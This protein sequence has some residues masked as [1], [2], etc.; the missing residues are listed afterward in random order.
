MS[1]SQQQ[2]GQLP[3][4]RGQQQANGG[5]ED[6]AKRLF[7][8]F[9][10]QLNNKDF[11]D[12]VA[13]MCP[14]EF[15]TVGYV[16][17]LCESIFVACRD[18]PDLL[19]KCDRASLFRAAERIAK[20]GLTVGDNVAWL[21]PYSG[22]VQDQ[23]GYKGAM[24]LVRR[25]MPDAMFVT[26]P[27]FANDIC[28]ISLGS[29]P[30]VVHRPPMRGGRGAFI[31]CYALMKI[32]DYVDVEWADAETIQYVR[33]KSPSKNSPAWNNWLEEQ[34]RKIPLKRLCKRQAN[35]R[36][37]DLEDM[38]DIESRTIDGVAEV[39]NVNAPALTQSADIPMTTTADFSQQQREKDPVRTDQDSQGES[40]K[41]Q[42]RAATETV[43]DD[44]VVTEKTGHGQGTAPQDE[45]RDGG[46]GRRGGK[47]GGQ[48]GNLAFPED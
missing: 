11:R 20:R 44:G 30:K 35:E 48:N 25:A 45:P 41:E 21:V 19:T 36:P 47:R 26:Q 34:S 2:R 37:L 12:R 32:G 8:Q 27:V 39:A 38:D 40:Q 1:M 42:R 23:L 22:Q 13:G 33:S 10:A 6:H 28:E 4:P 31:G 7:E 3:P 9:R 18:N 29:D 5:G 15:R 17:R 16:D 46:T 24:I 43:D 14:Q